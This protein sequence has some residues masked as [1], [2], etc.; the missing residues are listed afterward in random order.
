MRNRIKKKKAEKLLTDNEISEETEISDE[1]DTEIPDEQDIPDEE[2]QK[3]ENK[4]DSDD[5]LL[6]ELEKKAASSEQDA[7]ENYDRF[8]RLSA[9]FDNYRKRSAREV[10]TFKKFANETL[11]KDLLPVTDSLEM[12]IAS[13]LQNR[14]AENPVL[15]G[16]EITLR[17][18]LKVLEKFGVKPIESLEKEFNPAFHEAV[19]S[20][21]SENYPE[22]TVLK[23][24]Q[25]GYMLHDR[26]LRPA[27]VIVSKAKKKNG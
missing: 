2:E 25:K 11:L 19:M 20:E 8:V 16:V 4:E 7:K 6:K 26:L 17:E 15:K 18:L 3:T 22:N 21:E 14:D 13:S 5:N 9:E 12:A 24:L 23:E 10:E 27:T 1:D